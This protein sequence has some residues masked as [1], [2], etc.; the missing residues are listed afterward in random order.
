MKKKASDTNKSAGAK[1]D[2]AVVDG[3]GALPPGV[4]DAIG[5]QLRNVY[6]RML[7]EPLPDRFKKLLDELKTNKPK[8]ES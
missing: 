8:E 1:K 3:A 6:G 2:G 5:K 4:Q 7:A